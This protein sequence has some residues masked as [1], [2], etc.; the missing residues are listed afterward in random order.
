MD[1]DGTESGNAA[2]AGGT[3]PL[4]ALLRKI[5]AQPLL[6]REE[7]GDLARRSRAGDQVATTRLVN[8]HLPFVVKMARKYRN[9]GPSL[10][11]LIQ[12]GTVG[13]M[14]AVR[15]FDPTRDVR[16]A[17]Y[18]MW[19]VRAAIQDHVVRSWSQVR[20]GT[21]AKQK[22]LFFRLRRMMAD[23]RIGADAFGEELLAPLAKRFDLPLREV[24]ILAGRVARFDLSLNRPVA[25][26]H[27]ETW[28]DRLADRAPNPEEQAAASSERHFWD[29]ILARALDA[30]P[31]RE[32]LIIHARYLAEAVPTR[33]ALGRDRG[34]ATE[35]VRQL[36]ARAL[37]RLRRILGPIREG[38]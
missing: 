9:Y 35:R 4:T 22:T 23:L 30:L 5:R 37:E 31:P 26:G 34:I 15:R 6:S 16:F 24:R 28:L 14:N 19:W 12:E 1:R 27:G 10:P 3:D 20:V 7:E 21:T 2:P 33:E 36:E 32:Q 17:T 25:D 29:G 8:S 11:D 13:L 18:A 38:A